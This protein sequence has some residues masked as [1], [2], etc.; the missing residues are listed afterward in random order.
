MANLEKLRNITS[1]FNEP[2]KKSKFISLANALLN[3]QIKKA[4]LDDSF[5]KNL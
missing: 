4:E 2:K 1:S 5:E 3:S